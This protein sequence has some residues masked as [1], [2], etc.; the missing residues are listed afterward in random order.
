MNLK[1]LLASLLLAPALAACSRDANVSYSSKGHSY[2]FSQAISFDHDALVVNAPR[3]PAARIGANGDLRIG[4]TP[5]A[6]TPTQRES[7]MR[8][9]GEALAVRDDGIA[10]GKAGAALGVRAVGSV[11][12]NLL[13]GTPDNIDK[14]MDAPSKRVDTSAQHL[15][16]DLV[17]LKV[18]QQS[19]SAQLPA[20][21]PY[22][23]F[24]GEV[25]C[26][27]PSPPTR[28]TPPAPPMPPAPPPPPSSGG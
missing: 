9:Y 11:F 28:P 6:V 23:V 17:Q 3:K 14:D 13:A 20:F 19:L 2:F 26:D 10:T 7:L 12:G 22:Q 21:R 8:Y 5:V 15:C 1:L 18:T 4:D 16:S 25:H 24:R 27:V